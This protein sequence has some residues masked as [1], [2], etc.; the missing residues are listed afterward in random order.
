MKILFKIISFKSLIILVYLISV[1]RISYAQVQTAHRNAEQKFSSVLQIIDYAYVDT[2]NTNKLTEKAIIAMLKELDPHSAYLSKQEVKE[3][4]EQLQGSFEGIGIQ[5]YII[6]DTINVISAISGGP[7]EK[8]GIM[9]YDKIVKIDG[10]DAIGDKIDNNFV[11]KKL[12]GDKGT[13]VN[14]SIYR[15]GY[16]D[17]IE[18]TITRDKIPINSIDATFMATSDIGYIRLDRFGQT[19]I[20]E[21]HEAMKKLDTEG[22]KNLI[23]DLRGNGGGYLNTAIELSDEFLD[24]EKLIV[25]TE[26][27]HSSM[28]K[29]NSTSK[30]TFEKGK[31]IVLIDE[32][33][34]S[35]SEIVSGA[36]QDWDRALLI[37][38]RSFGKGL[39]QRPYDLSDGSVMR[40]TT[41]RYHT[42]TG[43]CIQKPYNNGADVYYK[44]LMNRYKNGELIHSDSIHFPD[45]LKYYTH[46]KRL[47]YGGGGIMPDIFIPLDTSKISDYYTKLYSKGLFYQYSL[48]LTNKY[49]DEYKIQYPNFETFDK[50]FVIDKDFLEKFCAYAEKEGV[51]KDE[52]GF[53][54]SKEYIINQIKALIVRN[55]FDLNSAFRVSLSIDKTYKKAIE[56]MKDNTFKKYKIQY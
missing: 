4:N 54:L 52:K 46:A 56:M 21:F 28:Q 2:V 12:R 43:R 44:D 25:Y 35:A 18:Y 37:G 7:S 38:R 17:L 27:I 33:S 36:V 30:G 39:V 5:F 19:S 13:K 26:G 41:A 20:Q 40:L 55:I 24:T 31:L 16:K 50:K 49:S 15:K 14:I 42:P 29:Y 10:K 45:S 51:K 48:I 11:V 1:N 22:M 53:E 34:A 3:S 47:V 6:K 8:L 23:L 32:G 9:A